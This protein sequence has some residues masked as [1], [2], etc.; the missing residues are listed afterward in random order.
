MK[1]HWNS[2]YGLPVGSNEKKPYTFFGFLVN[3]KK[4]TE[5]GFLSIFICSFKA[6]I[7][8]CHCTSKSSGKLKKQGAHPLSHSSPQ[9]LISLSSI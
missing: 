8:N 9:P 4:A 3:F 2:F 5:H 1:S 7:L 6:V